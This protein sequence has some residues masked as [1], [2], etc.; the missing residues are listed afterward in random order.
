MYRERERERERDRE[1]ERGKR[2]VRHIIY[3]CVDNY[4]QCVYSV[5]GSEGLSFPKLTP[6]PKKTTKTIAL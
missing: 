1:R 2:H 5:R 4:I 6:E 3:T